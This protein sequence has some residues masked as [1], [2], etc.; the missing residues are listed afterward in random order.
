MISRK[1]SSLEDLLSREP[2]PFSAWTV[3]DRY[4]D[5]SAIDGQR[6]AERIEVARDLLGRWETAKIRGALT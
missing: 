1:L 5:G 6:S 4:S 3:N 2:E